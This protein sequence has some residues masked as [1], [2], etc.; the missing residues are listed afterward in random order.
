[1]QPLQRLQKRPQLG[2]ISRRDAVPPLLRLALHDPPEF[3]LRSALPHARAYLISWRHLALLFLLACLFRRPCSSAAASDTLS[4]GES[5]TGNRTLVLAGGEFELGF[6]SP[7]GNSSHYVGIR[8]KRIP[9]RTV[10]WVM[11]R[12]SPVTDP[13][14]AELTVAQDG[15]LL[16]LLL[17]T[18]NRS[19]EA[20]IWSSNLTRPCDEG[21]AVAVLLDTGNLVLRG[22]C[23]RGGNSSAI[24]WRSFDHPTDTLVPGGWL[25]LNKSTGAWRSAT[26]PSTGLYTDRVLWNDTTV[27]HHI[28]AWNGRYFVPI[29]E[30]GTLPAK[31]TFVFVNSS[32]EVS[33]S[34]RVVD[35]STVSRLVMG[36]HAQFD[37]YFGSTRSRCSGFTSLLQVYKP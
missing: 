34:F 19:K 35:P 1:M 3:L 27:Y 15:S 29:A 22:R 9:G 5:L 10:I 23:Q 37:R 31:Y 4:A 13:S 16:L 33:Y 30:M 36:P 11:N 24:I 8:Y 28:G 21:T 14:S 2:L 7:A 20:M 25:G 6:F 26:D 12:D 17:L 18:G 32:E